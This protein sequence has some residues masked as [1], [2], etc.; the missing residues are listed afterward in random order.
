M[1]ACEECGTLHGT[2]VR[3]VDGE[4]HTF[5]VQHERGEEPMGLP[6]VEY[7]DRR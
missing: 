7:P 2:V 6:V 3:I 4:K 1:P 5:C